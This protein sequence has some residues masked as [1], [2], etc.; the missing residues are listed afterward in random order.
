VGGQ[1][2]GERRKIISHV[3][4]DH[5]RV[6]RVCP[7]QVHRR[8]DAGV[9]C[10]GHGTRCI[11]GLPDFGER[12]GIP[13]SAD[14]TRRAETDT[15]ASVLMW[16]CAFSLC[17]GAAY[18]QTACRWLHSGNVK[19]AHAV[20]LSHGRWQAGRSPGPL[21]PPTIAAVSS[22]AALGS[23]G[24]QRA[25]YDNREVAEDPKG[26]RHPVSLFS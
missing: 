18:A 20:T 24:P 5:P 13:R 26:R 9:P 16:T 3:R 11:I 7:F 21:S 1:V 17:E 8:Y 6:E 23:F 14:R 2:Y 4:V 10:D 22:G 25:C 12:E 15:L 19:P